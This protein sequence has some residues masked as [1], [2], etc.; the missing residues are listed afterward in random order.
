M[1]SNVVVVDL[2]KNHLKSSSTISEMEDIR[3]MKDSLLRVLGVS[4][5]N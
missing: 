4:T 3:E 5:K 2:V 1:T